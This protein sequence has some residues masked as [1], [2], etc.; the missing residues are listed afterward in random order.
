[1]VAKGVTCKL[2]MINILTEQQVD[3]IH[4]GTLEVLE[5]TGVV[6]DHEKALKLF[7]KN[8]C[9]VDYDKKRVYFPPK[10]VEECLQQS[11]ASWRLKRKGPD[12]D[13]I[14]GG[15]SV[16]IA[17]SCGLGT[18]DLNNWQQRPAT[19][20]EAYDAVRVVDALDNICMV[21]AHAPYPV[22][23]GVPQVM[24]M[25]ESFAARVRNT[26]KTGW[27]GCWSDSEIFIIDM[28]RALGIEVIGQYV[29]TSP[30]TYYRESVDTLFRFA[31]AGLPAL[32][33]TGPI[34][35][36]SSPATIAGTTVIGNAE[37]MAGIVLGQ[38]IKPGV[39]QTAAAYAFPLDMRTGGPASGNIGVSLHQAAFNQMWRKYEIPLW[40][41]AGGETSSK[42]IDLQCGYEKASAAL[43]SALSGAN[44]MWFAG[45]LHRELE[46][47]PVQAILDNDLAGMIGRF[48]EGVE[49]NDETLAIDL[50]KE[51]GPIP[52]SYLGTAHTRNWWRK[53]QY[54][55]QVFDTLTYPDWLE[56]GK[57]SALDYAKERME[58][59]LATH[60]PK[61]LTPSED[62]N[63]ERI[64]KEA[65]EYFRKKGLISDAD[66][67]V[68][69]K[70]LES[71][72]YPYE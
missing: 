41:E 58:E 30:L 3:A 56:K 15:K 39:R 66:W 10:L 22:I 31:E 6:F 8:G 42:S 47:H 70:T 54:V 19:R 62:E 9:K 45:G 7:E 36:A 4:K 33:G 27:V 48:L 17:T 11:P 49:V 2:E 25:P 16:Y 46:W 64:L 1:M 18:V 71:P 5:K 40:N 72:N 29:P 34:F 28:A 53:E 67:K 13:A 61:P 43:L 26:V 51:V 38:L 23:Q 12:N 37:V 52:G 44:I 55:P 50:I 21:G 20:K 59:I 68:Y 57:K 65:R 24:G 32:T 35:G 60:K 14:L 63:I 69:M